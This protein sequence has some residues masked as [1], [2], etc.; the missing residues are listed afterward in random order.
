MVPSQDQKRSLHLLWENLSVPVVT[1]VRFHWWTN[2]RRPRAFQ[3]VPT[4]LYILT[5]TLGDQWWPMSISGYRARGARLHTGQGFLR[6]PR[7]FWVS[8]VAFTSKDWQAWDLRWSL[9]GFWCSNFSSG[10][11]SS[12]CFQNLLPNCTCFPEWSWHS[13]GLEWWSEH[14]RATPLRLKRQARE[15][16]LG[17]WRPKA[18]DKAC[19]QTAFRE[20]LWTVRA[21]SVG[22]K[23]WV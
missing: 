8:L 1:V 19:K 9:E 7:M 20:V 11:S 13:L 17:R 5:G 16:G 21:V 2:A 10:L 18:W 6:L 23:V 15:E 3:P 22:Q 4:C 14:S 12:I